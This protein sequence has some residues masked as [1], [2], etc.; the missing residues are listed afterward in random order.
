MVPLMFG[1]HRLHPLPEG[2]LWWPERSTLLVADLHLEKASAYA[3]W[4]MM[5]P[6]YDSVDTLAALAALVDRY[7]PSELWCLGDSFHDHGAAARLSDAACNILTDLCA[8]VNWV[9][10]TGNHDRTIGRVEGR[11]IDQLVVDG[12]T[13]R[14]EADPS[15]GSH[16]ISGH[17][18]PKLR[19]AT[20][21]RRVARRCFVL[22]PAKLVLPAF[23]SLTGGMDACHAAIRQAVGRPAAAVVPMADR[24]LRFHLA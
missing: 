21:G 6:P 19:L 4:G 16:E 7:R 8:R 20:R 3:R 18:H 15:D 11:V 9:W 23:G 12:L 22:A 1:G 10:I 13:I 2:A 14:H 17:F 5:L 24:L